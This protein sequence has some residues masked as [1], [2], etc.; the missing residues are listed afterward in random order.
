MMAGVAF[1]WSLQAGGYRILTRFQCG[2]L[3]NHGKNN[4]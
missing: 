3:Q 4:I 2:G 1:F